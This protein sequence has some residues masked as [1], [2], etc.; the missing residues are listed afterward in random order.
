VHL[1]ELE[2]EESI[3]G[4]EDAYGLD[5]EVGNAL[6]QVSSMRAL[7]T[8]QWAV[9]SLHAAAESARAAMAAA[10]PIGAW[11]ESSLATATAAGVAVSQG[12]FAEAEE[13]AVTAERVM[14]WAGYP[15]TSQVLYPTL[16]CG[17]ASVGDFDGAQ[18]ALDAWQLLPSRGVERFRSLVHALSGNHDAVSPF[19]PRPLPT[20]VQFFNVSGL[21]IA[22]EIGDHLDDIDRIAWAAPGIEEVAR[23]GLRF[24]LAWCFFIPRLAGVAALRLGRVKDAESWLDVA[25]RVATDCGATFESMR[26]ERDRERLARYSTR[27]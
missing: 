5:A 24:D 6:H 16:A 10:P 19:R 13:L 12:R 26:V 21:A 27:L 18:A 17:R 2:L 14:R 23:S 25:A 9:G 7:A 20:P 8:A 1:A 11:A 22:V 3:A 15:P 4:F